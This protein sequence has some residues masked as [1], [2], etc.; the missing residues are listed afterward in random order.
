MFCSSSA[1]LCRYD[2]GSVCVPILT[3]ESFITDD[4][5]VK[6][7]H[8]VSPVFRA[9]RHAPSWRVEQIHKRSTTGRT[10]VRS[11]KSGAFKV[12]SSRS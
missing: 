9:C 5:L 12:K 3:T 2:G 6:H 7:E 8:Y 10:K 4:G 11:G 1:E